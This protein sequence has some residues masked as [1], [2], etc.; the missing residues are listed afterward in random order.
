MCGTGVLIDMNDRELIERLIRVPPT[1]VCFIL[2][3]MEANET[4][5]SLCGVWAS[6]FLT[7]M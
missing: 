1:Y 4:M 6:V 5:G 7:T 3:F 2:L